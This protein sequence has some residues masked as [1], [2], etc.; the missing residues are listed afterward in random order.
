MFEFQKN[1]HHNKFLHV[2][3]KKKIQCTEEWKQYLKVTLTNVLINPGGLF[4]INSK[5]DLTSQRDAY[6]LTYEARLSLC[7]CI[8]CFWR[9]RFYP[10]LYCFLQIFLKEI[11]LFSSFFCQHYCYFVIPTDSLYI[12]LVTD[13]TTLQTMQRIYESLY[14]YVNK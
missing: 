3:S 6:F 2:P 9:L 4:L 7:E 12:V 13:E 14:P 5:T 1:C 10:L 11:Y 8:T